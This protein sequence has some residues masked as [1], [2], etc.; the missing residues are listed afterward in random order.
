MPC[1]E[2]ELRWPMARQL[3]KTL[4]SKKYLNKTTPRVLSWA[5]WWAL[6]QHFGLRG[7]QKHH[8]MEVKDFA[9]CEDDCGMEYITMR[10][11]PM[12]TR[13]GRLNTT[14]CTVLPKM[15][16]T[17]G[18]RFPVQ[19]FTHHISQH[20]LELKDKGPFL[21]CHN[22]QSQ[23]VWHKKQPFGINSI[24]QTMKNIIKNMPFEKFSKRPSNHKCHEDGGKET[25]DSK[26]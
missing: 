12:K 18:P 2:Q 7:R 5:M 23:E 1:A 24:D 3:R 8:S 13:Q 19:F 17:A 10:Q 21:P 20:P 15:F 9:F 11:H 4:D 6:S 25:D 14:C 22:R 16:I 26:C